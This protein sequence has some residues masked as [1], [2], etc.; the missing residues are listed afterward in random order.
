VAISPPAKRI[1]IMKRFFAV[2][3]LAIALIPSF[4]FAACNAP[5]ANEKISV[6]DQVSCLVVVKKTSTPAAIQIGMYGDSTMQGWTKETGSPT[7]TP[8]NAPA[9]LQSMATA[10]GYSVS[11]ANLGVFG[12]TTND[13]INGTNGVARTWAAEMAQSKANVVVFNDG[14]NDAMLIEAGTMTMAQFK[15]NLTYIIQ[16]AQAAGKVVWLET[17]NPR[18]DTQNNEANVYGVYLNEVQYAYNNSGVLVIDCYGPIIQTLPNWAA[19]LP[20]DIHPDD[21]MYAFKAV[22]ELKALAPYFGNVSH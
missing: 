5:S 17:P 12:T 8:Y 11:V 7:I 19:H 1:K 18:T 2:A 16:T 10:L 3:L 21:T 15:S 6:K 20:D 22:Q 4:A 9:D 13:L 14:I